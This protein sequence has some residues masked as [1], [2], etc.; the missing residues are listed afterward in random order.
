MKY[1]VCGHT[2]DFDEVI[3]KAIAQAEARETRLKGLVVATA[4][5]PAIFDEWAE[6]EIRDIIMEMEDGITDAYEDS[7]MSDEAFEQLVSDVR[8]GLVEAA[9]VAVHYARTGEH[10]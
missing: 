1:V 10:E 3:E 2:I 8:L 6:G 7:D 5:P 4:V 9:E